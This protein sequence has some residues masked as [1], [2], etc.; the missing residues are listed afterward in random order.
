M[1]TKTEARNEI[2]SQ[3]PTSRR[4]SGSTRPSKDR[5]TTGPLGPRRGARGRRGL[6]AAVAIEAFDGSSA[7]DAVTT[8]A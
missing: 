3:E 6:A 5:S 1:N 8:A 4:L 2:S 7:A